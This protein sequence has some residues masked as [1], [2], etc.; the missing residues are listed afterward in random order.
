[1]KKLH[2]HIL[3]HSVPAVLGSV[4]LNALPRVFKSQGRLKHPLGT[5]LLTCDKQKPDIFNI[6]SLSILVYLEGERVYLNLVGH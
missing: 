5:L 1:M 2:Q 4:Y 6:P 3:T